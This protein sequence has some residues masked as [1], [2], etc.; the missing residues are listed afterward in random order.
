MF[1]KGGPL[2]YQ[3]GR[4]GNKTPIDVNPRRYLGETVPIVVLVNKNSASGS[5]IIAAGIRS[6]GAGR[7]MGTQTAGCVGSGQP[8]DL[9]DG[10]LILVTLTKMQDSK[11]GEDLNGPGKGVVPDQVIEDDTKTP[12]VDE[13]IQAAVDYIH[14]HG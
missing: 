1:V 6:N 2:V 7:V 4:D 8:K 10:G 13:V 5:E 11:T 12:Q 9:P 14:A 3:T